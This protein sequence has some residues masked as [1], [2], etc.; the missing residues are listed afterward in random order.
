MLE[1]CKDYNVEKLLIVGGNYADSLKIE[2]MVNQDP[3][4]WTTVGIHPCHAKVKINIKSFSQF[5][6]MK[7]IFLLI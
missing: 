2:P 5:L 6:K 4:F 3:H 7:R 1:R